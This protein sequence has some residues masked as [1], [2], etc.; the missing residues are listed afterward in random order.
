MAGAGDTQ[1]PP[2]L[3]RWSIAWRNPYTAPPDGWP[4]VLASVVTPTRYPPPP[5][6]LNLSCP[7][8]GYALC[9]EVADTGKPRRQFSLAAKQRIRGRNLERRVHRRWPLFAEEFIAEAL[10]RKP[11][12]YGV[13]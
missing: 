5:E 8:N 4:R 12:Y 9:F 13:S 10:R 1:E 6:L 2:M 3:F 7:G 11:D